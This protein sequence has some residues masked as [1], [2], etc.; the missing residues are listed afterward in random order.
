MNDEYPPPHRDLTG[1]V[2]HAKLREFWQVPPRVDTPVIQAPPPPH[3]RTQADGDTNTNMTAA[4][5]KRAERLREEKRP[6]AIEAYKD[7]QAGMKW[8]DIERKYHLTSRTITAFWKEA[9]LTHETRARIPDL[10]EKAR[11]AHR[12]RLN[13]MTMTDIALKYGVGK[14]TMPR[15][16]KRLGLKSPGR[17]MV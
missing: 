1:H 12:D 15:I 9:G 4:L 3:K 13:G 2:G 5:L 11:A 17:W 14:N 7:W 10:E 16:W 6:R 8:P